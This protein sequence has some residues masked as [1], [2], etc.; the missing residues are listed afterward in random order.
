MIGT[1]MVVKGHN[2]PNLTFVGVIDGDLSLSGGDLRAGERTFQTLVQVSGRAGRTKK[3]GHALI[4]THQPEHEA[5]A[6]LE[7]GDRDSF[8]DAELNLR[9]ALLLPPFGKLAAVIISGND[10]KKTDEFAQKF[11]SVAPKVNDL[12]ILGP[13]EPVM[14]RIRGRYRRRI[15]VQS[16]LDFNLS[17]YMQLWRDKIKIHANIKLQIDIDPQSFM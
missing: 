7:I 14:G 6:A 8:I 10:V 11:I 9:E 15:L 17:K 13:S 3:L 4:Q 1:Q 5:L 12:T 2:F 16:R